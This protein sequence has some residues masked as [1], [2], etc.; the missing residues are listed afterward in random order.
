MCVCGVH[1]GVLFLKA[2]SIY[3]NFLCPLPNAGGFGY[4]NH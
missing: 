3:Y 1:V 2:L 4:Y